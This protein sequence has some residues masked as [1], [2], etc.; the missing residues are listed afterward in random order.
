MDIAAFGLVGTALLLVF[1]P[2]AASLGL[3]LEGASRLETAASIGGGLLALGLVAG[4]YWLDPNLVVVNV[5]S[6]VVLPIFEE[7]IFRGW[8]WGRLERASAGRWAGAVNWLV[9][10]LLFGLWHFG[11]VDVYLLKIAPSWPE[12]DWGM[13]LLMKFLTTF[14][15]GFIVG[16]P[17]W[18]TGRVFG[19]IILHGLANL[20]GR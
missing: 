2:S 11:Y 4:T 9:V 8:G 19:S 14:V 20:F 5:S 13:F 18:R 10:S 16:L 15:I 7:L 12:M 6:A 1:R 3:R 17:R